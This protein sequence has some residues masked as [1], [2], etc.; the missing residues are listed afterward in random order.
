MRIALL[1]SSR[2]DYGIYKPLISKIL[3]DTY[4]HLRIITF[5]THLSIFHGYTIKEIEEDGFPVAEKVESLILGDSPEAI[6]TAIA[7]TNFKFSS[8][9]AK[10]KREI[11]LIIC[12]GDRYEMFAAVLASVPF[13]IPI[14]HIHGGETTL[15]AID[16]IF[17]HSITLMSDYH[18]VAHEVFKEKVISLKGNNKNIFCVGALSLDNLNLLELLDKEAFFKKYNINLSIPT[19]L[20]TFH[21]ET[22]S[23]EKNEFY[24]QELVQVLQELTEQYQIVITMPNADTENNIIRKYLVNLAQNL[25][26]KVFIIES[27][28]TLGYFSCMKYCSFVLGNSSSGII[29]AA[30]LGK[31][32]INVGDRQKGRLSGNNI[33]HVSIE[34]ERILHAVNTIALM[35]ERENENIYGDG[36]ASERIINILK[37]LSIHK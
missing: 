17:R 22:V 11:D 20:F 28:G 15:G 7:S 9:W 31:Y 6:S 36:K 24:I 4:F 33:F 26:K 13:R 34:K 25:S 19:I 37:E 32:V 23:T 1:T 3:Q 30:S 5:G 2:A 35:P 29:E 14:A 10:L 18:F 27:F 8:L 21:P 16:N 12:L